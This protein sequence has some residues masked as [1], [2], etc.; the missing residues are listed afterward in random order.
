MGVGCTCGDGEAGCLVEECQVLRCVGVVTMLPGHLTTSGMQNKLGA[1]RFTSAA[2]CALGVPLL[3]F[4]LTSGIRNAQR[5][6]RRIPPLAGRTRMPDSRRHQF[7]I[8]RSVRQRRVMSIYM[9]VITCQTPSDTS[10]QLHTQFCHSAASEAR[11][12]GSPL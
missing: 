8:T 2:V 4:D 3:Q 9:H 10:S 12:L 11:P 5:S 1:G 7:A 6:G